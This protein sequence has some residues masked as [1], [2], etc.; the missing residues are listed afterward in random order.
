MCDQF[1]TGDDV[2]TSFDFRSNKTDFLVVV[3]A[4]KTRKELRH[5]YDAHHER[6]RHEVS[7]VECIVNDD[8]FVTNWE[9]LKF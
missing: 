3:V 2:S 8:L 4:E 1:V 6:R 7:S 9:W 5:V